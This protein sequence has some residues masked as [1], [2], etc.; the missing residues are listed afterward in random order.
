MTALFFR[1]WL[2]LLV[3][4]SAVVTLGCGE[5]LANVSGEVKIKDQPLEQGLVT[6]FSEGK[7][8]RV[9]NS[10]VEKGKYTITGIPVGKVTISVQG[11]MT[12]PKAKDPKTKQPITTPVAKKYTDPKSSGLSYEVTAGEQTHDL[13]VELEAP[14]T[15]VKKK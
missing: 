7:K 11:T 9:K 5:Q 3:L 2:C 15:P 1:R 13:T 6:F 4:G 8:K 14:T 10:V 12:D